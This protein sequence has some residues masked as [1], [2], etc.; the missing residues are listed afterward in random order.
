MVAEFLVP[1]VALVEARLRMD[2]L[3]EACLQIVRHDH[4]VAIIDQFIHGVAA[5]VARAAQ[6]QNCFH[7][8]TLLTSIW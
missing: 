6:Y 3:A 2:G 5:N 4:V 7:K 8:P 1:D